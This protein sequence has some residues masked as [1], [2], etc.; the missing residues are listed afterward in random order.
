MYLI[1]E[2]EQKLELMLSKL[3]SPCPVEHLVHEKL[4]VCENYHFLSEFDYEFS[5]SFV[6]TASNVSR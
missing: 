5:I 1:V 2:D 4:K 3:H 6:K